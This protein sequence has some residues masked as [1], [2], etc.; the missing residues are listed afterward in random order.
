MALSAM[1]NTQ[2]SVQLVILTSLCAASA[3]STSAISLRFAS[4][5]VADVKLSSSLSGILLKSQTEMQ[6][7]GL[8]GSPNLL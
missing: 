4:S 3:C 1:M 5:R 7:H 2:N 8:G 6:H